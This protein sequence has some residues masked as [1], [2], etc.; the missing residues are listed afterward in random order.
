MRS[1]SSLLRTRQHRGYSETWPLPANVPKLPPPQTPYVYSTAELHRLI[2][3]TSLLYDYRSPQQ[4]S[5]YMTLIL[6]LYGSGCA[7][8]KRCG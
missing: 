3:A 1:G 7:S 4:A 8:A 5:M 2:D 6:L